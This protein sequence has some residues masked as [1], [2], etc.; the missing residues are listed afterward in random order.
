MALKIEATS[1]VT[2]G[3]QPITGSDNRLNV[4]SRS[5]GRRYYNSRDLSLAFS[6]VWDDSSSA[7]T[8]FIIYWK[9]TDP[10]GRT[11][12]ISSVGLN[13]EQ[14]SSFKLHL[15][16]GTAVGVSASPLCLNRVVP[17]SAQA[18]A[19]QAA[20]TAIT[21]L[22]SAGEVDHA[23]VGADGHEEFRL[24]DTLRIGQD[25]AIAIEYEQG[26]TGRTWGVI[27]GYYE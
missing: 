18:T 25:G 22:T 2:G 13:A 1:D 8:D 16:T 24:D 3:D 10:T 9:N 12:V 15:V 5:D 14:A 4:S 11:L 26:T 17:K 21:G 6:L 19:V 23:S 20:G 27:F 7:A